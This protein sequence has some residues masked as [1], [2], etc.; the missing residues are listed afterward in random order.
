MFC[1]IALAVATT[2]SIVTY[3]VYERPAERYLKSRI[4]QRPRVTGAV[5]EV[6]P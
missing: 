6:L 2:L 4:G 3:L 5:A 1:A